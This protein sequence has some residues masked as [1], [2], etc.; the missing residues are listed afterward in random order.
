MRIGLTH[1]G[2]FGICPVY[3]NS[4]WHNEPPYI[5]PRHWTLTPLFWFS[6]AM[7]WIAYHIYEIFDPEMEIGW[8]IKVTGRLNPI[9]WIDVEEN[10]E[11]GA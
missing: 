3:M 2:W 5:D 7:C 9:C 8:P 1:K 11:W 10:D 4:P 6:E